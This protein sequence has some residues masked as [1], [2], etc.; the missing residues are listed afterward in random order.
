MILSNFY[1]SVQVS[2][3]LMAGFLWFAAFAWSVSVHVLDDACQSYETITSKTV[4]SAAV[5]TA[6]SC[7]EFSSITLADGNG[8][9][10]DSSVGSDGSAI[11]L[12]NCN[13]LATRAE[14][15]CERWLRW[16]YSWEAI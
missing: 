10:I 7:K 11:T 13:F 4:F 3:C 15:C 6:L 1:A 9:G 16:S 2:I 5:Q 14:H 8:A 12:S